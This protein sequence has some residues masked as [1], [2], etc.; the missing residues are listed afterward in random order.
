MGM[1][2]P[3]LS[4]PPGAGAAVA[5]DPKERI[6]ECGDFKRGKCD[7]G[8]AC[9]YAHVKPTQECRDY[10]AGKCQRGANCK[11]LHVGDIPQTSGGKNNS[12][13]AAE[14]EKGAEAGTRDRSRSPARAT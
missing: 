2:P 1:M 6:E 4:G 10:K 8:D 9:R 3:P 7:R 5:S 14:P 12:S 11:F 13:A